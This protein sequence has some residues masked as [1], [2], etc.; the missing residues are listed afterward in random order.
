MREA[1]QL[2]SLFCYVQLLSAGASTWTSHGGSGPAGSAAPAPRSR[3]AMARETGRCHGLGHLEVGP[4]G[5]GDLPSH[6]LGIYLLVLS[7][8]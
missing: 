6:L 2:L 7:R 1:S 3:H 4:A 8:E 5:P